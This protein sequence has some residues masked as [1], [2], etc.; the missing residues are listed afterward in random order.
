MRN[1]PGPTSAMVVRTGE[2]RTKLFVQNAEKV[3]RW[4]SDVE[5]L[6]RHIE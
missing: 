5:F 6:S 4:I 1:V 3:L 2:E